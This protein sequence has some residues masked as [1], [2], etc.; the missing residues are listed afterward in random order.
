MLTYDEA[1]HVIDANRAEMA[2]KGGGARARVEAD[3]NRLRV[4]VARRQYD[5]TMHK[6]S[7]CA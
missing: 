1:N 5:D 3:L 4:Q 7:V 6:S 2:S